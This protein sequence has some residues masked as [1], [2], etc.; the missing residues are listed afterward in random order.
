MGFLSMLI[1]L[2]ADLISGNRQLMELALEKVRRMELGRTN[3][4]DT[5]DEEEK[6]WA[7]IA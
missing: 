6:A 3:T 5:K 4:K 2:I 1:G 7:R